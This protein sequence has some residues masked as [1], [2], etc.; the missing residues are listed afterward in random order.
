MLRKGHGGLHQ[1]PAM[2]ENMERL[3]G[4]GDQTMLIDLRLER[5]QVVGLNE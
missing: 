4:E 1:A 3:R 5:W 2:E